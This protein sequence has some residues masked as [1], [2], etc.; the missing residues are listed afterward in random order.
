VYGFA[1]LVVV[2]SDP[3]QTLVDSACLGRQSTVHL[4][5]LGPNT[6]VFNSVFQLF[7]FLG[8]ATANTVASNSLQKD[9]LTLEEKEER[10]NIAE[11]TAMTA[12]MLAVF[13]GILA[14]FCLVHFGPRW[15]I[16]MGTDPQVVPYAQEYMV[17]RSLGTP[18][19][20]VMNACQ[21]MC[22]GQQDTITPMLVCAIATACNI[23]GDLL[24]IWGLKMGVQG[25]AIATTAAQVFATFLI[26]WRVKRKGKQPTSI[27]LRW[28]G[29]PDVSTLK[30][31]ATVG[32]TLIA[33]TAV[34][35]AAYFSM[36]AAATSL[37]M[38]AAA[39]HQVAMQIFWFISFLPEPLSMAAQTLVAKEAGDPKA[40][41]GWARLLVASGTGFGVFLALIAA[42]AL[43]C[44]SPI[45]T[46]DIVVQQIVQSLA[47]YAA[48][49]MGICGLMMM[50]DGI[51]I[52]Y[53][54]T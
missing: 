43:L 3:M 37:G 7:S 11:M 49:A 22:L 44:A 6:A 39:A 23:L 16:L 30:M 1:A 8:V 47:P 4:A 14:L 50:F 25:A 51:S 10:R 32:S 28:K 42:V 21:G 20:L 9:G 24:L 53:D 40:A 2:L 34:G 41:S 52:G 27:D 15:L 54:C 19:V 35:M 5:A 36:T 29:I 17:I 12:V 31:F 48:L 38:V 26:L 46:P 18:F 33:R 13:F 45:F